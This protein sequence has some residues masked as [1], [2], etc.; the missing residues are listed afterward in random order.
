MIV[1][2]RQAVPRIYCKILYVTNCEIQQI[3]TL[4][5]EPVETVRSTD[6]GRWCSM[7]YAIK[8]ETLTT[9]LTTI[10]NAICMIAAMIALA[11]LDHARP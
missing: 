4:I 10:T 3:A 6:F 2:V 7:M 5:M 11:N 1:S 8:L 9:V